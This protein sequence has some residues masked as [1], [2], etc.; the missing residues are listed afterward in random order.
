MPEIKMLPTM[1]KDLKIQDT[2]HY[3]NCVFTKVHDN[4][5]IYSIP[6]V[7]ALTGT[8]S[9]DIVDDVNNYLE[10]VNDN[11]ANPT[12]AANISGDQSFLDINHPL[13]KGYCEQILK[14]AQVYQ[15]FLNTN[16]TNNYIAIP[17]F[18]SCWSVKMNSGDY[19]PKHRHE[20][21]SLEGFASIFYT[22]VPEQISID[23]NKSYSSDYKKSS[24]TRKDGCL[25]FFWD[26]IS[27]STI[28]SQTIVPNVG[29]YYIFPI[30]LLHSVNPYRG[31]GQRWSVQ[32]NFDLFTD[33][34]IQ[35]NLK[36]NE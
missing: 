27:P 32:S 34:E 23:F 12:L 20:V 21:S 7:N 1:L 26:N 13:M 17:T 25:E 15:N 4:V 8:M 31:D 14:S 18:Q 28:D 6:A 19:N 3:Y 33:F 35:R 2:D 30:W 24:F 10:D 9:Q 11:S 29:D 36:L 22:K 5:G 16:K